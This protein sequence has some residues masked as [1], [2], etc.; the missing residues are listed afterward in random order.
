M[1][2]YQ[3]VKCFVSVG[4]NTYRPRNHQGNPQNL[5]VKN[6]Q[7]SSRRFGRSPPQSIGDLCVIYVKKLQKVIGDHHPYGQI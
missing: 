6:G 1:L 7:V 4:S 2:N 3:V 5:G